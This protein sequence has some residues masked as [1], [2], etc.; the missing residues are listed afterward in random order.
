MIPTT[1]PLTWLSP[2]HQQCPHHCHQ[3]QLCLMNK[4]ERLVFPGSDECNDRDDV[5]MV[6]VEQTAK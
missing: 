6:N 5:S 2:H 1:P 3:H 4:N